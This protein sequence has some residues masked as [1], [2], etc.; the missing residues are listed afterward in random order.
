[1]LFIQ[2]DMVDLDRLEEPDFA[3]K[4]GCS[5]ILLEFRVQESPKNHSYSQTLNILNDRKY[6]RVSELLIIDSM[7][8]LKSYIPIQCRPPV[9]RSQLLNREFPFLNRESTSASEHLGL[10]AAQPPP[11]ARQAPSAPPAQHVQATVGFAHPA[12]TLPSPH[13]ALSPQIQRTH[14]LPVASAMAKVEPRTA[15]QPI[16]AIERPPARFSPAL[17]PSQFQN[18]LQPGQVRGGSRRPAMAI[19]FNS[20]TTENFISLAGLRQRKHK[21]HIDVLAVVQTVYKVKRIESIGKEKRDIDIIDPSQPRRTILSGTPKPN[22]FSLFLFQPIVWRLMVVWRDVH[23]F[24]PLVGD[25]ILLKGA[26]V[27]SYDGRSL[28]AYEFTEMMLNPERPEAVYL[29]EWWEVKELASQGCLEELGEDVE[30]SF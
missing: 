4:L 8:Y 23:Q 25:I 22:L 10:L 7:T 17:G 2:P 19:G 24:E 1:M 14:S 21:D 15:H 13:A 29:R 27:H 3:L 30:L 11:Q 9:A 26:S 20:T 5:I 18:S 6:L 12:T 16:S 28:N